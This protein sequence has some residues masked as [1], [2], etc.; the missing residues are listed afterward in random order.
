MVKPIKSRKT[1][2]AKFV[3]TVLYIRM[4]GTMN[5]EIDNEIICMIPLTLNSNG[6]MEYASPMNIP[7]KQIGISQYALSAQAIWKINTIAIATWMITRFFNSDVPIFCEDV[8]T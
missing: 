3:L 1:Y 6:L 5:A 4:K 8:A 7:S 2:Q